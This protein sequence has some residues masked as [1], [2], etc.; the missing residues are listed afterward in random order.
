MKLRVWEKKQPFAGECGEGVEESM[1][2]PMLG[3]HDHG[4]VK[5]LF[6]DLPLA[7]HADPLLLYTLLLSPSLCFFSPF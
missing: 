6:S 1:P 5:E 4:I 3:L 2:R 7:R